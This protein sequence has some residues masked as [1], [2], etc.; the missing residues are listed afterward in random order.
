M[1]WRQSGSAM[2]PETYVWEDVKLIKKISIIELLVET[3]D[4]RQYNVLINSYKS[5]A[6]ETINK[7]Y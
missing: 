7:R 2:N 6:R 5:K 4:G 1:K 3:Q